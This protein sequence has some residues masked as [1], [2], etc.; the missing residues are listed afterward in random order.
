MN[1]THIIG[2]A[3]VL[4]NALIKDAREY[5]QVILSSNEDKF[6]LPVTPGKYQVTTSQNNKIVDILDFGE[7]L[8]FGN[9]KLMKL[10]V[11]CFFPAQKTEQ[12]IVFTCSVP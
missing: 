8:I 1:L 12:V 4:A 11:G 2:K 7:R 10:K 9:E 6:T 5:R 3:T